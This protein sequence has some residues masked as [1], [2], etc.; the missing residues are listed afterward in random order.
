MSTRVYFEVVVLLFSCVNLV[1]RNGGQ[2]QQ[3]PPNSL[4]SQ[5]RR[6][7]SELRDPSSNWVVSLSQRSWVSAC[8]HL[9][10]QILN[11]ISPNLF[12]HSSSLGVVATFSNCYFPKNLLSTPPHQAHLYNH[13]PNFIPSYVLYIKYAILNVWPGM[14]HFW[15]DGLGDR[16]T[17][18][19]AL[20]KAFSMLYCQ[21]HPMGLSLKSSCP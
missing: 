13:L 8:W 18:P 3:P 9:S 14:L 10:S 12:R 15:S 20:K 17:M 11:L 21:N 2:R 1:Y 5:R 16:Q 4:D 6:P 7:S 19:V